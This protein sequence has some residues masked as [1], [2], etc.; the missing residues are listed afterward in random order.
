VFF[1]SCKWFKKETPEVGVVLAKHFKNKLY[2]KF[3][4]A[5]YNQVFVHYLDTLKSQMS[6]PSRIRSFYEKNNLSPE[7]VTKFYINGGLDSLEDYMSK[8][9]AHGYSPK[10]FMKNDLKGLLAQLDANKFTTIEQVYPVIAELEIKTAESLIKYNNLIY[11]GSINPR[12]IFNRYYI[13]VKRPD[14]IAVMKVLETTDLVKLLRDIQP[15]S[16]QYK[17]MQQALSVYENSKTPNLQAI[18]LIKLNMERLR[19]KMPSVGVQHV[20]VNIPDFSLT[21]F[22]DADTLIQ[23]KVCVGGS[24]EKD[25]E[26]KIKVYRQ[27]GK[28]ADKPKNH[29]TPLLFSK[30]NAIQVNPVWNIPNSIAKTEIY[31]H[32]VRNPNYLVTHNISVYKRGKVIEEPDTIQWANYSREKL[33]FQFKQGSGDDNALGKFKFIFDNGSSIYLHDTNN[34]SAFKLAKRDISHGCVRVERPLDFAKLLVQDDYQYDKL[35]MDVN[36]PPVDTTKMT[37]FLQKQAKK[38]D[39]LAEF[40]LKPSWFA[41]KKQVPIVINYMTAWSQNGQLQFRPDVYGL[42]EILWRNLQKYL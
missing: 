17:Q 30:F 15:Q 39:T 2:N 9:K 25:Y 5:A 18:R 29:E 31:S 7:F 37:T 10:L 21:W 35:R 22:K 13:P 23:M 28:V 16:S 26:E 8:V 40:E 3:D 27:T 42:D 24:K 33:P 14:S 4:T 11:Y 12:K 1:Q 34:K 20:E 19:W 32:V 36:L 6:N 41:V 38:T